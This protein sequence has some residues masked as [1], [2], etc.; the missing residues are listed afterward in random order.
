M[1]SFIVLPISYLGAGAIGHGNASEIVLSLGGGLG[2]IA[3][4]AVALIA[5]HSL[6]E[7]SAHASRGLKQ[8]NG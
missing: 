8:T 3:I 2:A 7:E 5:R 4:M 6:A 1:S